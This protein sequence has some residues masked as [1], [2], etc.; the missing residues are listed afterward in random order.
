LL[1]SFEFDNN[2]KTVSLMAE[3]PVE[4][5]DPENKGAAEPAAPPIEEPQ[6]AP[7]DPGPPVEPGA[8]IG[9]RLE[10]ADVRSSESGPIY[11]W[12]AFYDDRVEDNLSFDK[13]STAGDPVRK[14]VNDA[15]RIARKDAEAKKATFVGWAGIRRKTLHKDFKVYLTPV[16][17][18]DNP[19]PH[20]CELDRTK[21][22]DRQLA[23]SLAYE[24]LTYA[25]SDKIFVDAPPPPSPPPPRQVQAVE[26]STPLE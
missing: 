12:K 18:G 15:G 5:P 6:T 20:H 13:L 4:A 21:Y 3:T 24:L 1:A 11:L 17:T 9:R 16:T 8:V 10:T 19:N 7:A 22:P 26:D 14:V 23:R 25:N 2:S